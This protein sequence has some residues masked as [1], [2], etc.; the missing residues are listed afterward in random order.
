M[1]FGLFGINTGH[2]RRPETIARVARAAEAA[3]FDSV[4]TAEHIVLPDP[5]VPPSP[6]PPDTFLLD[7]SAALCFVAAHTQHIR[8]GTGIIILPQ[9]NPVELAKELASVDVL[10]DGRLIFGLG[11]GYLE[12]EFAAL[13]KAFHDRGARTDEYI[14]VLRALWTQASPR[15][16]GP[17]VQLQGMDAHPRPIQQPHPPIVVGGQSPAAFRRA[18]ARG[19]GWYGPATPEALPAVLDGIERARAEVDRPA[20]YGDLEI[21]IMGMLDVDFEAALRYS[22]LGVDR[23]TLLM[24]GDNEDEIV[25]SIEEQA[26]TLVRKFA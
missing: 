12:S 20:E 21:G 25:R 22:D 19:N 6:V 24:Q 9:R 8:L 4:W 23:V 15:F 3:G 7:P 10:S 16:S 26:E 2:C 17:T 1:K 11:V 13:G 5:Q 14:D 18:V